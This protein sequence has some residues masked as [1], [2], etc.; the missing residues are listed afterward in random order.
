MKFTVIGCLGFLAAT[1]AA[2]MNLP[3]SFSSTIGLMAS[4]LLPPVGLLLD[5]EVLTRRA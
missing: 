5:G 2:M 4:S 3:M 1:V